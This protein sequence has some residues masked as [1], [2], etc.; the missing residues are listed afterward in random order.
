M[1]THGVVAVLL[2]LT[3]AAC[4]GGEAEPSMAGMSAAEHAR[5]Q[6]GA[7]AG[8]LDSSGGATRQAVHL[9]AAE[10]RALGV[11]YTTVR[12]RT[13]TRTIRT[14]GRIEAAEPRIADVTP[15]IDGFVERLYVAATG[16]TVR[17]GQ[18]LL[19]I[20]SPM[21]V[22]AQEELLTA[23]R[24]A[25]QLDSS[26]GEAWH[27]AQG[28]LAAARRRLVY[29][30][31]TAGQI[32]RLERTGE[33]TKTLTLVSPVTGIVLEKNVLSGQQVMPGM[34]LYRVADLSEVWVEGDVFE[35]DLRFVRVGAP[36]HIELSAYPGEHLMGRVSFTYPTVDEASRTNRVRATAPNP[37]GRLKPGMYATMFF[38][39][40]VP[41][42]LAVPVAAVIATGE[43]NVVFVRDSGGMLVP[44]EVVL[45]ARA[46]DQV[47][48][49]DGLVE[50]ETIVASAN[51]LID[52]ESRLAGTGG[53]MPG[54][55]HG[56]A[57]PDT[58][59][60]GPEHRHD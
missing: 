46:G 28:M 41:A 48:V 23:K 10:E 34:R 60:R 19:A 35:Q 37:G 50:G 43:R 22:A 39:A 7:T 8:A 24:L 45:G 26:A 9:T 2:A 6:A 20:Y 30:D 51:F 17:R 52:A 55:Q 49:L 38:E 21:L 12:R 56:T 13:L 5:M 36:A 1:T 4:G 47:Q 53:A 54:M 18:P 57:A 11:T 44:H 15:K 3:M 42:V 40:A 16:E 58:A 29:W 14:V 27:S 33:V 25:A 31:I 32:D 59:S